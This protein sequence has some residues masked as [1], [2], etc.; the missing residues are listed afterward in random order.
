MTLSSNDDSGR[1]FGVLYSIAPKG[2]RAGS[3]QVKGPDSD[4][5]LES[6][7]SVYNWQWTPK[8]QSFLT[9]GRIFQVII[10]RRTV[11]KCAFF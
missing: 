5:T 1:D 6:S 8:K 4:E 9:E 2:T 7:M 10:R 11:K 3:S